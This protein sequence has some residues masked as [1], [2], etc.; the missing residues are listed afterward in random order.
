MDPYKALGLK[1]GASREEAKVAFR[2][3][4]LVHHPDKYV[5][6]SPE[7]K[8]QAAARFKELTAAYE[9]IVTGRVP[10]PGGGTSS[11]SRYTYS[12]TPRDRSWWEM[13]D[14]RARRTRSR[15]IIGLGLTLVVVATYLGTYTAA[16]NKQLVLDPDAKV[17]HRGLVVNMLRQ[18]KEAQGGPR[19]PPT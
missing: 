12:Y 4:A 9:A 11:S 8:E 5:N 1:Y 3:Q 7:E 15:N 19:P 18:Y 10:A 14:F 16:K 17:G 2:Q 6:S 13:L